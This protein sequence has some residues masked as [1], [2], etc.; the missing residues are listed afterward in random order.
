MKIAIIDSGVDQKHIKLQYVKITQYSTCFTKNKLE[1][2]QETPIDK[3]G[4]GTAC[5]G[6]IHKLVPSAEIL[7]VRIFKERL[8]AKEEEMVS[9]IRFCVEK[10]VNIINCSIGVEKKPSDALFNVC[11]EAYEKDIFIVAASANVENETYPAFFPFVFSVASGVMKS[12]EWGYLVDCRIK[13]IAKGT[14][15]RVLDIRRKY[16]I[17]GGSSLACPHLVCIIANYILI[18]KKAKIEDVHQYL[19][20]NHKEDVLPIRI[21]TKERISKISLD[22]VNFPIDLYPNERLKWMRKIAVFPLSDKEIG[23]IVKFEHLS[24]FEV[25]HAI[26]YPRSLKRE[27]FDKEIKFGISDLDY[28]TFD[29]LVIGY[30]YEQLFEKNLTCGYELVSNC[31][32]KDINIFSLSPLLYDYLLRYKQEFHSNSIIYTPTVSENDYQKIINHDHLPEAKIPIIAVIGTGSKQGKLSTQMKIKSIL[33]SAGYSTA[34]IGTEP[35]S[36]IIGSNVCF[37]IGYEGNVNLSGGKRVKYLRNIIRII[38]YY[39]APDIIISGTQGWTI[40]RSISIEADETNMVN[41]LYGIQPDA[42]VC[43]INPEDS[44]EIIEKT[45]CAATLFTQSKCIFYVMTPFKRGYQAG[46]NTIKRLNEDEY[47]QLLDTFSAKLGLP[48]FNIFDHRNNKKIL[49]LITDFFS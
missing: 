46:I 10:K 36:E 2:I 26:D 45:I 35:Q 22:S 8:A 12:N 1:I 28:Q 48:V 11:R 30:F 42:L 5:A 18:N 39:L 40:T 4:H 17:T 33:D 27:K 34:H 23:S 16:N 9:A 31:L 38:G 6:I 7:S 29:T 19:Q 32:K 21:I 14:L 15:Q 3:I 47:N 41:F 20:K 43:A 24:P 13:Y 25:V 49:K 37:P 44:M